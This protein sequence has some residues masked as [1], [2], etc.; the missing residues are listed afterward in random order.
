MW[1]KFAIIECAIGKGK[2][3]NSADALTDEEIEEFYRAGVLGNKTPWALLNTVWMNNC[4][5]FG[6]KPGQEQRDI[7]SWK[8]MLTGFVTRSF[9]PSAKQ[10]WELVKTQEMSE[11]ASQRCTKTLTMMIAVLSPNIWPISNIDHQKWWQT[12]LCFILLST[13]K[14]WRLGRNLM[15][16]GSSTGSKFT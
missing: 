16:Q 8:L 10:K 12:T 5:Y 3:P 7:Y 1:A 11:K 14:F 4:I 2:K 15:V 13:Q 9:S 6:M